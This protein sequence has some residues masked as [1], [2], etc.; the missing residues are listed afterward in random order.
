M[1]G[2]ADTRPIRRKGPLPWLIPG[3]VT[4]ALVP[5]AVLLYR[6]AAGTLGA[7]PVAIALNKLG[8]LALILLVASLACTP[9]RVVAG[10]T[11]PMRAR[12]ALGLLAFAYATLHVLTYLV[13]DQGLNLSAV[14]ADLYK[15]RFIVSGAMAY[16]ALVP[17]AFTSTAASV[18]RLGFA[19]W[20]RL[21]RLAYL[22]AIL[23]VVH[24]IWRVKRDHTEPYTYA[25]IL[26]VLFLARGYG[27]LRDAAKARRAQAARRG[28]AT[29]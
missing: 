9:L 18:R 28:A 1:F 25:A 26:G 22:A 19:K 20:K 11:W 14:I 29:H 15:R 10:W 5:L 17:L 7:N 4:G 12:R 24:F 13:V 23:G 21:H 16:A 8:L 3:I 2:V 27:K 6:V